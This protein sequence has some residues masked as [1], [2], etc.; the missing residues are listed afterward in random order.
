MPLHKKHFINYYRVSISEGLNTKLS[1]SDLML[2][3]F[4]KYFRDVVFAIVQL[5]LRKHF[6]K[7]KRRM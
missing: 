5:K 1:T 2:E 7:K 3:K 4:D 6:L